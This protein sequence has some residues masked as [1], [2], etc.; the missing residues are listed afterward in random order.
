MCASGTIGR[1]PIGIIQRYLSAVHE[2]HLSVGAIVAAIHRTAQ[3]AQSAVADIL[4]QIRASPVTGRYFLRRN[5]SKA[6]VDEALGDEFVGVLVRTSTLTPPLRR[7]QTAL[8]A[9]WVHLCSRQ[10]QALLRDIGPPKADDPSNLMARHWP[11]GLM[12]STNSTV[13]CRPS[14]AVVSSATSR[15]CLYRIRG[16]LRLRGSTRSAFG[17]SAEADR[18][19]QPA[20]PADHLP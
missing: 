3:K 10:G 19:A 9:D 14:Y 12:R 16:T 2:L 20:T 8:L 13:Y 6:M 4:A 11:S 5:R 1:L 15:A 7:P 17:Q 18:R